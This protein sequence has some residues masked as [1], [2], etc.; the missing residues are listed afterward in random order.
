MSFTDFSLTF[1]YLRF[2][3]LSSMEADTFFKNLFWLEN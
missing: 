2:V 3:D 1:A